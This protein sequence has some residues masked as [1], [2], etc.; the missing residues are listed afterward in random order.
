VTDSNLT[1]DIYSTQNAPSGTNVMLDLRKGTGNDTF[2][3]GGV[4]T[5]N[6]VMGGVGNETFI[7]G[8]GLNL[9]EGGAGND[10]F[11]L[12]GST[13][14]SNIYTP[15]K[16]SFVVYSG[17]SFVDY[18]NITN[19]ITGGSGNDYINTNNPYISPTNGALI[20]PGHGNNIIQQGWGSDILYFNN[21]DT[22]RVGNNNYDGLPPYAF[23]INA[24]QL[25]KT[26][27]TAEK[28]AYHLD[29]IFNS[30]DPT[31]GATSAL[32]VSGTGDGRYISGAAQWI[33]HG[34]NTI[35]YNQDAVFNS[36]LSGSSLDTAFYF[37]VGT[38]SGSA[39]ASNAQGYQDRIDLS[40][41]LRELG[42]TQKLSLQY[43]GDAL[44]NALANLVDVEQTTG[45][46]N[47]ASSDNIGVE[48]VVI[49]IHG[50][51]SLLDS[52]VLNALH[53]PSR[54]LS[55]QANLSTD[56]NGN[57]TFNIQLLALPKILSTDL[58]IGSQNFHHVFTLID[59]NNNEG[60]TL[61]T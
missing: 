19:V 14:I 36:K 3:G 8:G 38:G 17:A 10:S 34:N 46:K 39:Y 40:P 45:L 42:I 5:T 28:G 27:P 11:Y 7:G 57:E 35:I 21:T 33:N 15:N 12:D 58:Q 43:S 50:S 4:G 18:Y 47:P 49:G 26:L 51:T 59:P 44:Y 6:T 23:N 22:I 2:L 25:N 30:D 32:P 37:N 55:T 24:Q 61:P 16:Q 56:R 54:T 41:L 60:P 1:N 9:F 29:L 52:S 31:N 20:F 48:G 13:T 53:D